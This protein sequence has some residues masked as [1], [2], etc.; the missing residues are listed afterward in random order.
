MAASSSL[1]AC[2]QRRQASAQTRE[3][4]GPRTVAELQAGDPARAEPV[5]SAGQRHVAGELLGA[6]DDRQPVPHP[7]RQL[8]VAPGISSLVGDPKCQ[9]SPSVP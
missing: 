7:A 9:P 2:S 1:Q 8:R 4:L 6:T 5:W 3:C